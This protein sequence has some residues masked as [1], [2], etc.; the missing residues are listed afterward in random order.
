MDHIIAVD[1]R[2]LRRRLLSRFALLRAPH[3]SRTGEGIAR[4]KNSHHRLRSRPFSLCAWEGCT[5]DAMGLPN[6]NQRSVAKTSGILHPYICSYAA[7]SYLSLAKMTTDSE[8][9]SLREGL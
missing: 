2:H 5:T 8:I 1:E 3:A 9:N 4:R 7:R 6:P